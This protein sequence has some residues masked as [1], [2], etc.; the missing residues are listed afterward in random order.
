MLQA[1]KAVDSDWKWLY[2]VGG[3]SALVIGIV[4]LI[5]IALYIPM[6]PCSALF[7]SFMPECMPGN[8]IIS[9]T[10]V[11]LSIL[12]DFL[13]LPVALSL[14]HALKGVNKNA[15]L[16]ATGFVGLFVALDLGV[17]C[18]NYAAATT[19]AQRARTPRVQITRLQ[20]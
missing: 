15:M 17:T 9:W 11:G 14:Y 6:G 2:R 20:F 13:F 19:D 16:V 8:W 1:T 5:T 7:R 3:L 12:T 18:S 4:Y 10:I